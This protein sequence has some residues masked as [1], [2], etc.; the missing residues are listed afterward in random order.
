[1]HLAHPL[2][3]KGWAYRRVKN[4]Q[5]DARDLCDLLRMHRLPE[6][7]T[8]PSHRR[9]LR[10]LVRYRT[11]LVALRAWLKAQAH[12]VFPKEHIV[13]PMS[14]LFVFSDAIAARL[15]RHPG[16]LAI[17]GH[18]QRPVDVR[19]HLRRGDR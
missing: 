1:M 13:V 2:G 14:D 10:E 11:K 3:V 9:Q 4:D 19:G 16:Y 6:A 18:A 15:R 17:Q 7:W 8:A 5:V 12:A